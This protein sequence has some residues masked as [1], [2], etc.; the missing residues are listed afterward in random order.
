M[1]KILLHCC[2][3]PCSSASIE[4]LL[5]DGYEVVLFYSNSN[6]FP[7]K[8]FDKRL[9]YMQK[10]AEIYKL[11]L[12]VGEYDHASW[13]EVVKGLENEPEKGRRCAACFAYNLATAEAKAKELGIEEF[14]TTLTVSPHKI[15][16]MIFNAAKGMQGYVPYNF[17]K[18]DGFKKSLQ[19]SEKYG[20]Y[21][22]NYCGCEYSL[23][24]QTKATPAQ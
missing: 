17:K 8:E 12:V 6:I 13:S 21:R 5:A 1:K 7:K 16:E 22:Q 23:R 24:I 3:A 10:L 18:Q 9:I 2:C 15:S 4:R 14:T 11:E 20:L 19:L